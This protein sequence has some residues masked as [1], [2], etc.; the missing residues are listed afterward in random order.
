MAT[1][2]HASNAFCCY[3]SKI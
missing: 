2:D 3:S 1:L